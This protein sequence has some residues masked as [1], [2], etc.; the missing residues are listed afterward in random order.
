MERTGFLFSVRQCSLSEKLTSLVV[1]FESFELLSTLHRIMVV[2]FSKWDKTP[3]I[4]VDC[5]LTRILSAI[6]PVKSL[7]PSRL[8]PYLRAS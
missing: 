1:E 6:P 8:V 4:S 3:E 7:R 2:N 5:G